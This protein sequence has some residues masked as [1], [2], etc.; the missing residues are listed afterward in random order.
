M[1][2][3]VQPIG[4]YDRIVARRAYVE[5]HRA[6][7]LP[8][9]EPMVPPRFVAFLDDVIAELGDRPPRPAA[10]CP[11]AVTLRGI[12]T[13]VAEA[14]D[15]PPG[16]IQDRSRRWWICRPRFAYIAL[17]RAHLGWSYTKMGRKLGL[18]HTSC[19]HAVR[20]CEQLCA[21]DPDYAARYHAALHR[22]AGDA[23]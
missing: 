2:S 20:R 6:K 1:T 8:P 17:L 5:R 19:I 22:V 13:A 10:P 21:S 4:E 11:V 9:A 14:F 16:H 15:V 18:N 3:M 23:R 7:P 12:L